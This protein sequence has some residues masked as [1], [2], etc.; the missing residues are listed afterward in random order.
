MNISKVSLFSVSLIIW[1]LRSVFLLFLKASD[2]ACFGLFWWTS[3]TYVWVEE[4]HVLS[5]VFRYSSDSSILIHFFVFGKNHWSILWNFMIIL[6]KLLLPFKVN[7]NMFSRMTT[8][9][10]C[11]YA[12]TSIVIKSIW[13]GGI[14]GQNKTNVKFS[15]VEQLLLATKSHVNPPWQIAGWRK[16]RPF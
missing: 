14:Q 4:F 15:I 7:F 12:E 5:I 10:V 6:Y 1:Y 16:F 13:N 11:N 2:N 3:K 8:I 9:S